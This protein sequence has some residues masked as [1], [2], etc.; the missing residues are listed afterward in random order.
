MTWADSSVRGVGRQAGGEGWGGLA[1][2]KRCE[3]ETVF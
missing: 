2:G 3:Q 1:A